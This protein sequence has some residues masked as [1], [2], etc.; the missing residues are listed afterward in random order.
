LLPDGAEARHCLRDP[1]CGLRLLGGA[2]VHAVHPVELL[3]L[4][5]SQNGC[6][7]RLRRLANLA[8]LSLL[9]IVGQRRVAEH[10]LALLMSR[11]EEAFQ[12]GLLIGGEAAVLIH[13]VAEVSRRRRSRIDAS[14]AS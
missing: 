6:Q 4:L 9:L 10:S 14:R 13:P 8:E 12:L 3:Q 5:R 1:G 7:L 11:L 2:A